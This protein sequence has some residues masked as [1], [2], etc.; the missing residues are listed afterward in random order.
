MNTNIGLVERNRS[1]HLY[2]FGNKLQQDFKDIGFANE[3]TELA[4]GKSYKVIRFTLPDGTLIAEAKGESFNSKTMTVTTLKDNKRHT[5]T[6]DFINK[7]VEN[8]AQYLIDHY[9]L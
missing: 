1:A 6:Y 9:Y 7:Q 8:V 5:V 3:K 2:V 4:N